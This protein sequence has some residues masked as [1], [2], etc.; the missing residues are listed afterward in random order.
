M[1]S[2]HVGFRKPMPEIYALTLSLLALQPEEVIM[3]GDSWEADV[4]GARAAGI[5]AVHLVREGGAVA[6]P[7]SVRDLR[8]LLALLDLPP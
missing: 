7:D 1:G 6:G 4:L 8:G 2:I 5:R 3:V